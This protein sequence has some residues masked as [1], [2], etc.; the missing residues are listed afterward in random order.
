MPLSVLNYRYNLN[1]ILLFFFSLFA[2]PQYS[3][4]LVLK[5]DAN[6]PLSYNVINDL[7]GSDNDLK[8]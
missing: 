3:A 7:S 4:S 6:N 8:L 1:F 5:I 2:Q